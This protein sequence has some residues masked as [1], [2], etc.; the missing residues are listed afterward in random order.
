M[1]LRPGIPVIPVCSDDGMNQ[2]AIGGYRMGA[3]SFSVGTSAAIRLSTQRPVF[4][5]IRPLGVIFRQLAI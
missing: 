2:I 4:P 5:T 1:G 3:M